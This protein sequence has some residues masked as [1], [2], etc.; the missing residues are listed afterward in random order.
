M[1]PMFAAALLLLD[2][3][4]SRAEVGESNPGFFHYFPPPPKIKLPTINIPFFT[5]DVK[6]AR[7]AYNDGNYS[8]ALKYFRRASEDGNTVADWFLA[9]MYRR[10]LGTPIDHP[11]A[12][13]YYTRVTESFDPED[14]DP[15]RLRVM[16][17]SQLYL[18]TYQRT[19]IPAAGINADPAG[20]ARNYLRIASTYGHPGAQFA[21]GVMNITGDGMKK[22]EPQG[23][24]WLTAAARKRLPEAQAYLGDLYWTGRAVKKSETRALMWYTLAQQTATPE[25]HGKIIA[26][27]HEMLILVD[28]ET[29]LEAEARDRIWAEQYPPE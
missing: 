15:K 5:D 14:P 11:V 19:G 3:P 18:A 2:A 21:L 20:A 28:G 10:G 24:K 4:Q 23:L 25:E 9:N 8:K 29:R 13:S 16:V 27:Y 1:L 12:F 17:D 22:N 7:R 6:R 26:R